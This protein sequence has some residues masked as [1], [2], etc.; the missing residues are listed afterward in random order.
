MTFNSLQ[1]LEA[2][3]GRWHSARDKSQLPS[4]PCAPQTQVASQGCPAVQ[5]CRP[6]GD[7]AGTLFACLP[8]VMGSVSTQPSSHV[9]EGGT[10]IRLSTLARGQTDHYPGT[11]I[12]GPA[13]SIT[14]EPLA[15]TPGATE[16][17]TPFRHPIPLSGHMPHV[18][19][20]LREADLARAQHQDFI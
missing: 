15:Q 11:S 17:G 1:G 20:D 7:T 5:P 10:S 3:M 19:H 14:R 9:P 8:Q 16:S 13:G 4:H 18:K 6:W 12:P 2:R